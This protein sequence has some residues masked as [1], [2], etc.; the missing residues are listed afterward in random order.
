[1]ALPADPNKLIYGIYD[2]TG[3]DVSKPKPQLD[4]YAIF[5]LNENPKSYDPFDSK[6][7]QYDE[8]AYTFRP[9]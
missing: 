7:S 4:E 2:G 1:M 5:A 9:F 8:P 3:H 6:Q